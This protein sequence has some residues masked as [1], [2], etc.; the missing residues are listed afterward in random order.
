MM[1]MCREVAGP[2]VN[3]QS[4]ARGANVVGLVS[5]CREIIDLHAKMFKK[6]GITTIREPGSFNGLD[7]VLAHQERS[8]SN[9]IAAPRIVPYAGFGMGRDEPIDPEAL[10]EKPLWWRAGVQ[11]S[12]LAA[13]VL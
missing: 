1:D 6:H 10:E 8:A 5:Q 7:W 12:R 2:D 11:L 3:L 9:Q 13:P 4:L